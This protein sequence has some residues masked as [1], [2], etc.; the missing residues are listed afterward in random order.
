MGIILTDV[1]GLGRKLQRLS[2]VR[3]DAVIEKNMTQIYNRGKSDGGT[4]VASGECRSSCACPSGIRATRLGTRRST[5]RMSSTA[6]EPS[7]AD[8]FQASCT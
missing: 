1:N 7:T 5:R 3:Y 6:T 8:T 4:P 2:H